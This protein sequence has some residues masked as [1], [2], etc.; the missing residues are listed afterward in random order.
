MKILKKLFKQKTAS[1][2]RGI[3]IFENT[4]EVI[5]AENILKEHGYEIKV[6]GPPPH[7]RKGCDLAIEFPVVEAMGILNVLEA[8][9]LIPLDFLPSNDGNLKPVDLFHV[10]DYGRFIMV[11]AANMKI[12]VH[13]GSLTIVNIS[14][15]GCPD[16]PYLA[17]CLVGKKINEATQPRMLG[18][19]LCGYALQLAYDKIKE[20]CLQS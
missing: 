7:V 6:V 14:G 8:Q 3:L 9:G 10:K 12:T 19:T 1:T 13:K 11:R 18:H 4:S 5:R 15:G 2:Y 17:A 20:L 16:V